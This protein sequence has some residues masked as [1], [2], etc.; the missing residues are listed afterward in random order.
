MCW[1]IEQWRTNE[2]KQETADQQDPVLLVLV[3]LAQGAGAQAQGEEGR[4]P[5]GEV[6]MSHG[7]RAAWK[8]EWNLDRCYMGRRPGNEAFGAAPRPPNKRKA[9]S[10]KK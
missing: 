3:L 6:R 8:G 9:M 2:P 10:A 1:A 5:T 7:D 4:T